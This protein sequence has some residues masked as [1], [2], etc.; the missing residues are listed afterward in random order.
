MK[1]K[2]KIPAHFRKMSVKDRQRSIQEVYQLSSDEFEM[3]ANRLDLSDLADVLVESSVGTFPIPLGLATGFLVDGEECVVPMATEEPSVIAAASHGARLIKAGGGFQTWAD[4][5]VMSVQV[6]LMNPAEDATQKIQGAKAEIQEQVNCLIPGMTERGG[7]FHG[8]DLE[9]I[10]NPKSLCVTIHVNV[11]DAMGANIVNTVAE[12][13]KGRLADLSGGEVLMAIVTNSSQ[14]RKAGASFSIP[15]KAFHKGE[16]SGEEICKR[17]V[18]AT[19]I[20]NANQERAVTHNKGIM[21]GITALALVTGND[22]RAIEA[23]AYLWAQRDGQMKSLTHYSFEDGM[24]KGSIE[25]PLALGTVGGSISSWP[26]SQFS[27]KILGNP[28]AQRLSQMA[29][30]LGLAQNLAALFAL[31]SEGIQSGHMRLHAARIAYAVGAR[32]EEIRTL[33]SELWNEKAMDPDQ[34]KALLEKMRSEHA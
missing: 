14:N 20:A 25:L 32:G 3:I 8:M 27:L 11:C 31:V 34:A 33:A 15:C 16:F 12:S 13:I 28:N 6:F 9:E 24:L 7:G 17:I 4:E 22:T 10:S 21:N 26:A 29:A 1:S 5:S 18:A 2:K 19:E 30:A 23:G